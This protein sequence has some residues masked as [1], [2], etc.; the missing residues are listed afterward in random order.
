MSAL[1]GL[2]ARGCTALAAQPELRHALPSRRKKRAARM[3]EE[4][5]PHQHV[6]MPRVMPARAKE[7]QW[8]NERLKR[9]ETMKQ[10]P[11]VAREAERKAKAQGKSEKQKC[12]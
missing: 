3:R 7:K 11:R 10:G 8:R 5:P 6:T 1:R 9:R 12:E 4:D 2:R